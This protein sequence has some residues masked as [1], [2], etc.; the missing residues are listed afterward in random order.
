MD[1]EFRQEIAHF[2]KNAGAAAPPV[3]QERRPAVSFIKRART[4]YERTAPNIKP[5]SAVRIPRN[6]DP[7]ALA[8]FIFPDLARAA[9]IP[10]EPKRAF[11]AKIEP[12]ERTID[13]ERLGEPAR[14]SRQIA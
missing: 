14:T 12:I 8:D 2:S 4:A 13:P 6:A 7:D 1:S 3:F 9:I 11:L 5:Q 10:P